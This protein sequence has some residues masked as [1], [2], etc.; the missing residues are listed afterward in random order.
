MVIRLS[1]A[2]QKR[3]ERAAKARGVTPSRYVEELIKKNAPVKRKPRMQVS[4]ARRQL[5]ELLKGKTPKTDFMTAL[6]VARRYARQLEE[7]NAEWIDSIM[8]RINSAE[9]NSKAA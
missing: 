3:V 2:I 1:P 8:K 5:N 6:H 9:P 7:D 4:E